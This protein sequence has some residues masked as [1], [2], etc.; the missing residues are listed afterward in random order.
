MKRLQKGLIVAA[1]CVLCYTA[2]HYYSGVNRMQIISLITWIGVL[3]V[4]WMELQFGGV[5]T[6]QQTKHGLHSDSAH[7]EIDST[8]AKQSMSASA[9]SGR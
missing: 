2:G 6:E 7:L 4:T 1:A 9:S 3:L 5:R 8:S